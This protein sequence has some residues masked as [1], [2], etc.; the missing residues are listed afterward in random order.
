MGGRGTSTF[1]P[2]PLEDNLVCPSL[3]NPLDS[4]SELLE[5]TPV[6][7]DKKHLCE[8]HRCRKSDKVS[9]FRSGKAE[10]DSKQ[11]D[12]GS[13]IKMI[14]DKGSPIKMISD[15]GSPVKNNEKV[16]IA[17]KNG[18]EISS[19]KG[20]PLKAISEKGSP[21]KRYSDKGSPSRIDKG[22]KE[23]AAT[24]GAIT[25]TQKRWE[26]WLARRDRKERKR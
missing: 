6:K 17:V 1:C 22:M 9:T 18:G 23:D 2:P 13:S 5:L 21:L 25:K 12:K 10:K 7:S 11:C 26:A 14:S 15:K 8:V 24:L 20:S 16:S 4:K 3:E 19:P